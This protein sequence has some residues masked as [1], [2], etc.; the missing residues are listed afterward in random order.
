MPG[1]WG[2]ND[3]APGFHILGYALAL[4]GP[5]SHLI[6]TNQ[7]T[8]LQAEPVIGARNLPVP[9]NT[10]RPLVA[11][12]IISAE[13]PAPGTYSQ[14]QK[15]T[16]N[17]TRVTGGFY[18]PHLAAHLNGQRPTGGNIGFKDGHAAWRK[19]ELMDQRANNGSPGFWW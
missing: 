12:V 15:L 2:G 13:S 14:A 6:N 3:A 7:N 9:P 11:D 8:T 10:D 19:F 5:A 1:G 17:Y 18:K 16:Y 4:S